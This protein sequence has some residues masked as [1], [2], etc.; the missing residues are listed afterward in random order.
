[1]PE[2]NHAVRWRTFQVRCQSTTDWAFSPKFHDFF[3]RD[4]SDFPQIRL[5]ARS[6][7]IGQNSRRKSCSLGSPEFQA[8]CRPTKRSPRK[9]GSASFMNSKASILAVRTGNF[10]TSRATRKIG[11]A[12]DPSE[13]SGFLTTERSG[14]FALANWVCF[15]DIQKKRKEESWRERSW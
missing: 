11:G 4:A 13:S 1:M 9:R 2:V 14:P 5:A 15:G 8:R 3:P 12:A 10:R 6:T 7:F